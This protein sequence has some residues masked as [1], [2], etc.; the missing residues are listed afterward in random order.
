MIFR[1]GHPVIT[2]LFPI[3]PPAQAFII[4]EAGE[5]LLILPQDQV[6][7]PGIPSVTCCLST[8]AVVVSSLIKSFP[9]GVQISSST[10]DWDLFHSV[11]C[12]HKALAIVRAEGA[13]EDHC[14]SQEVSASGSGQASN[15][16]TLGP[17]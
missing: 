3:Q 16:A 2:A 17:Q 10:Q 6:A 9:E 11:P 12:P 7:F 15:P 14:C 1:C 8:G 13:P 4:R 5:F